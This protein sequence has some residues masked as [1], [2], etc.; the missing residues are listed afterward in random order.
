[1]EA[2]A[3]APAAPTRE[4]LPAVPAS[5]LGPPA[6]R[7]GIVTTLVVIA[8]VIAFFGTFSAWVN[9]Q[10]FDT[11]E[12]T[13]TSTKLL[14]DK[15]IRSA[16]ATYL[17]D[18]LYANVDVAAEL[19][20]TLPP[21][22]RTLAGPAAGLLREFAERAANRALESPRV[23]AAWS[24]ANTA[25]HKRFLDVIE[26][27]GD[28]VS[29]TGGVV[30]LDLGTLI[31][32]LSQRLG[33][34]AK[35]AGKIPP[36]AGQ[37][38]IMRSDQLDFAQTVARV[39]RHLAIVFPLLF[40]ALSALAIYLSTGRRRETL[41]ALAFGFILAGVVVLIA[42]GFAGDAVVG[43]LAKTDSVE[44]A[45]HNVWSIGTSLLTEIAQSVITVGVLILIGVWFAGR[46]RPAVALRQAAAPYM[47]ER[48][49][50]TYGFVVALFL[51][52]VIWAP[53]RAFTRA[54]PLLV[55]AALM[56]IG[57]EALRRQARREFPDA[58]MPEGGISEAIAGL[59]K[60]ARE[61]SRER[62]HGGAG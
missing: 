53:A 37:L 26:D 23:Q 35:L 9:Q 27:R 2:G 61:Q 40:L 44:P 3:L 21:E 29:T 10:V 19:R 14:E 32:N 47:R 62:P 38:E 56:L 42:Q 49:G 7:R 6:P 25:A 30:T 17:V 28:A 5:R 4:A 15:E 43:A 1:M 59:R 18:E 50:L 39:I 11:E 33:I 16:V 20:S 13:D 36:D 41:R 22:T 31:E 51:L 45:V 8:S 48:P 60:G 46:T 55:I 24:N 52:L 57:T 34:G 58:A 12:W 54:G